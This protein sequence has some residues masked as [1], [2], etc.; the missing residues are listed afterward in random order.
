MQHKN[1]P[2]SAKNSLRAVQK[3]PASAPTDS[4]KR[5]L[6]QWLGGNLRGQDREFS[7]SAGNLSAA[8]R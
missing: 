1:S 2:P 8:H 7:L 3:F 5:A 6:F 4:P